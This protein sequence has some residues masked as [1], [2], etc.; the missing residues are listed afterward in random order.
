M[1]SKRKSKKKIPKTW[2]DTYTSEI[3]EALPNGGLMTPHDQR[4]RAALLAD[5]PELS[6]RPPLNAGGGS[7]SILGIQ[8]QCTACIVHN[9]VK[10]K[11]SRKK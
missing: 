6:S 9:V 11:N 10:L 8:S 1:I 7:G 3:N 5:S 4:R 2:L